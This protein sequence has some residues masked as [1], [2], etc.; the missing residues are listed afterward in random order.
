MNTFLK[1]N[2]YKNWSTEETEF[3]VKESYQKRMDSLSDYEG[4]Y[5]VC[6]LNDKLCINIKHH[7]YTLPNNPKP[8]D[9]YEMYLVH[10]NQD[11]D[12]C[13]L[14][15]YSLTEEK[16]KANLATYEK[17]LLD[18]WKVFYGETK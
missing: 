9:G 12:W 14:K 13:D 15:I 18:M 6:C 2:G 11:G 17:Q 7:S 4:L 3:C 5:P 8:Y 1:T 10:E 16:L